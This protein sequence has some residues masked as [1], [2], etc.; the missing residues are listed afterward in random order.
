MISVFKGNYKYN[1]KDVKLYAPDRQGVYYIGGW[2]A[3]GFILIEYIGKAIGEGVS[4]KTKLL[5]H[6]SNN[7]L[8]KLSHF[9]FRIITTEKE[10]EECEKS[11]IKVYSPRYNTHNNG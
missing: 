10:I 2:A 11:E 5:D 3:D 1:E 7:E 4:I 8:K 6:L 9:A